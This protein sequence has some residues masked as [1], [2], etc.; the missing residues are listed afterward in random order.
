[1]E[2]DGSKA[3]AAS[4]RSQEIQEDRYMKR[5]LTVFLACGFVALM[6]TPAAAIKYRQYLDREIIAEANVVIKGTVT[7][8][9][10]PPGIEKKNVNADSVAVI[11]IE[12]VFKGDLKKGDQ[13]QLV[14]WSHDKKPNRGWS[15]P[16]KY[17]ANQVLMLALK[18]NSATGY[19]A[20]KEAATAQ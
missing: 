5:S 10:A 11:R 4:D 13:I 19:L 20:P 8:I 2:N 7:R 14:Y 15:R 6:S 18:R 3:V 17:Q 12:Q 16:D 9:I 1:M